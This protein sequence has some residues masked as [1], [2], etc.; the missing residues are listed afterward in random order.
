MKIPIYKP[1]LPPYE[2]VDTDIREMY[3]S[4]MLYPGKFTDRLVE[5]VKTYCGVDFVLPVSSC[6]LG[7]ILM[8]NSLPKDAKVI[9]PAFTFNATLQALEWNDLVP[10]VV[11]VDD[12][13]QLRSDLVWDCLSKYDYCREISHDLSV[14]AVLGVHM[15][16][17]LLDTAEFS[18]IGYNKKVSVFY[19]GAH[20][21]GSFEGSN[22]ATGDATCFSIAATKPVS[23]GEGGLIVTNKES[24]YR[25]MRDAAFH[26]KVDSL[27]T[28]VR[29]I[30]G[31]IQEFNSILAYHALNQ[32]DKTKTRRREI[33]EF[34]RNNLKNT[35]VRIWNTRKGV[36][37]SYKDCVLF[38]D[39]RN[40]LDEFVQSRGIGTKRYFEPP[41][42][43]MGS[44]KGIVHSANNARKLAATCL[45]LPLYPAL[46]DGEVE[47]IVETIK[48]FFRK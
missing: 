25:T 35:P 13:G 5:K 10:V 31:K 14:Q 15:W 37:A 28:E 7:L 29:G 33:M 18:K 6:S 12:D 40:E 9:M 39:Q 8:L 38:T 27:D 24:L 30:N 43:D 3:S 47:Y 42:P 45:T 16:G 19:D 11:D 20:V 21:L 26:G 46:K 41:I 23:A 32:F 34:Y 4:G 44:F 1:E 17:N 48:D 36:D 22:V 2:I